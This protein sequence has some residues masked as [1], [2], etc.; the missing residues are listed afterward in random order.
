M[1]SEFVK[2][3]FL[4]VL[5]TKVFFSQAVT[6]EVCY[7]ICNLTDIARSHTD[8]LGDFPAYQRRTNELEYW[9]RELDK[10]LENSK[11]EII[12][13]LTACQNQTDNLVKDVT[14]LKNVSYYFVEKL[15]S[16]D[17][18]QGFT[19]NLV[20][21]VAQLKATVE[22]HTYSL[23][24]L[25]SY[26]ERT[27]IIQDDIINIKETISN[28]S[29]KRDEAAHQK[30][31]TLQ[32]NYDLKQNE[33]KTEFQKVHN[34]I[35]KVDLTVEKLNKL[36]SSLNQIAKEQ[37]ALKEELHTQQATS[38]Q[39]F[40]NLSNAIEQITKEQQTLTTK[41]EQLAGQLQ[42]LNLQATTPLIQTIQPATT[43][44]T[45]TIPTTSPTTQQPKTERRVIRK[46]AHARGTNI[47]ISV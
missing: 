46:Y 20:D 47:V 41:L 29:I 31:D 7:N 35:G 25:E 16:L 2:I 22:S 6:N 27:N 44:S 43:P 45:P 17:I 28:Y 21:D 30:I 15:P 23:S 33:I 18:Y 19:D 10:N 26:K 24:N 39:M 42:K 36:E 9:V 34:I 11:G 32:K 1:F 14:E 4:M 5:F 12:S 37:Y 38:I 8:I 3:I 40:G 13:P